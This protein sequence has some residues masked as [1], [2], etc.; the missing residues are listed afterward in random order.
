MQGEIE[1]LVRYQTN[2]SYGIKDRFF[3]FDKSLSVY[4]LVWSQIQLGLLFDIQIS[5][6]NPPSLT[7]LWKS[8]PQVVLMHTKV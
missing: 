3:L 5:S 6:F 7:A 2:L 8:S 1:S 4:V